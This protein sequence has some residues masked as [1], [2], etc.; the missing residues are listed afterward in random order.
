MSKGVGHIPSLDGLRAV[1]F[2]IVFGSHTGVFKWI[3][4]GFGV[5]VFFFLSGF[6]ITTL[7][8]REAT[9]SGHISLKNFYM[10][11]V[12]RIWPPFYLVLV[13]AAALCLAGIVPGKLEGPA[14]AAQALHFANYWAFLRGYGGFPPGTGVYWSLAVEEH[15]YLLFPFVYLTFVRAKLPAARQATIL[16]ALCALVLVWRCVVTFVFHGSAERVFV[17]TDTRFD[18][19]LF[20]CALAVVGNPV[21]DPPTATE[22]LWKYVFLP[23]G[24]LAIFCGLLAPIDW[25]KQTLRYTLQGVGLIPLFVCAVRFPAWWPFRPLNW[26]VTAYL[27]GLSYI[28]YLVHQVVLYALEHAMGSRFPEL[29]IA[30]VTLALSCFV[31]W[32]VHVSIEKPLARVRRRYS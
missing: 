3:P 23:L 29:V 10:R 28:L 20:G 32:L 7:L 30:V 21:L 18:S 24:V 22:R 19:I 11:R 4:G 9:R 1:S 14:V 25:M 5:T 26:R 12:L 8:R 31:A 2:L 15:F 13:A 17:A 16:Y 6:L 27:G